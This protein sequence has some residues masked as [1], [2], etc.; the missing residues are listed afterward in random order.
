M[1][2][3]D[4]NADGS[5]IVKLSTPIQLGDETVSRVTIP[6]ITGKHLFKMPVITLSSSMGP[7]IEWA[8]HVVLPQGAVEELSPADAV[9]VAEALLGAVGKSQP[10]GEP[11]SP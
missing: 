8:S 2:T 6:R 10:A 1:A 9:S 7:V 5:C 3:I 4:K 11:P